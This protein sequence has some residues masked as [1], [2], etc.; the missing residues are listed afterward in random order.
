MRKYDLSAGRNDFK[1]LNSLMEKLKV[2][3]CIFIESLRKRFMKHS[4]IVG[5]IME[6]SFEFVFWG[7]DFVTITEVLYEKGRLSFEKGELNTYLVYDDNK[8]LIISYDFDKHGNIGDGYLNEDFAEYYY[9]EF[10]HKLL[11]Y[12]AEKGI[13]F[14]L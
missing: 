6:N 10:V 14:R 11:D 13:K 2:Q 3:A 9:L 8:E 4:P 1:Y 5:E 7:L 12:S